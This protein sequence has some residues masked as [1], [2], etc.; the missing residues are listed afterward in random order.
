MPSTSNADCFGSNSLDQGAVLQDSY[1]EHSGDDFVDILTENMVLGQ[2]LD[3]QTIGVVGGTA[4]WQQA[5]V[6][7]GRGVVFYNGSTDATLYTAEVIAFEQVEVTAS[8]RWRLKHVDNITL[9]SSAKWT[10]APT[11]KP[12]FDQPLPVDVPE[13]SLL[14][15]VKAGITGG[16]IIRKNVFYNRLCRA[17]ILRASGASIHGNV[18]NY[19]VVAGLIVSDELFCLGASRSKYQHPDDEAFSLS[20]G[21]VGNSEI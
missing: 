13:L 6:T 7:G 1:F 19:T 15:T 16:S 18:F 3:D 14:D 12:T 10:A 8:L 5:I 11:W 17:T 2:R 20:F 21:V 9:L 4:L